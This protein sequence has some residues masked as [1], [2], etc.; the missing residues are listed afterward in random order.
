VDR[1]YSHYWLRRSTG[2][3][4]L[5]FES[6]LAAEDERSESSDHR[7]REFF[8][9]VERGRY[10]GQLEEVAAH[11]PRSAVHVVIFEHM[12]ANPRDT[13]AELCRFLEIDDTVVPE[14][15]GAP[16]NSHNRYRSVKVRTATRNLPRPLRRVVGKLNAKPSDYPD[17][18]GHVR[19]ALLKTFRTDNDALAA[20]LGRDLAIWDH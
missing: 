15:V 8:R 11:Y 20:W 14:L 5:D 2:K 10:V 18:D 17:M 6:A 1:A 3:E 13:Y 12:R 7:E 4:A 9:Y 16:I 19:A